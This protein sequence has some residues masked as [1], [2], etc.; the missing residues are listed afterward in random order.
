VQVVYYDILRY[1]LDIKR[2]DIMINWAWIF[3]G[4]IV[5]FGIGLLLLGVLVLV[6]HVVDKLFHV[7]DLKD[8]DYGC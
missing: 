1:R 7:T 4:L 6:E 2:V 3:V 8:E 5:V